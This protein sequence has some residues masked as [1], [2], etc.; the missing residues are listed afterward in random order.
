[1]WIICRVAQGLSQDSDGHVNA[2]VEIDNCAA[3]PES[4]PDFL[5]G[6]NLPAIRNQH[7]QDL[8][9][10]LSQQGL[11]VIPRT[12]LTRLE[13]QLKVSQTDST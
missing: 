1:M 4:P 12:Q 5:A 10:L 6:D 11:G 13:I 9:R 2:V 8:K 3:R 7:T